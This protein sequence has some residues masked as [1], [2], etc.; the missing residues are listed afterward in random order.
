MN[1]L[2]FAASESAALE[3]TDWDRWIAR[4]EKIVGHDLDGDLERDGYSLDFLHDL[5][6]A[7]KRPLDA[8]HTIE[9][10]KRGLHRV[11]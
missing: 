2:E 7:G 9:W 11:E 10:R 5:F 4:V 3:P 8:V 6:E 1:H